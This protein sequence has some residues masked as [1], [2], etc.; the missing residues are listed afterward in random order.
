MIYFWI[1]F[2]D[3]KKNELMFIVVIMQNWEILF[4]QLFSDSLVQIGLV[5]D[6]DCSLWHADIHNLVFTSDSSA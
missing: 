3:L 5:A 1:F 4:H 2:Y 6:I